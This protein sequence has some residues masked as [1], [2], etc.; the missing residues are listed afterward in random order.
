MSGISRGV[1]VMTGLGRIRIL[2][3][4]ECQDREEGCGCG[5]L[6]AWL[7]GLYLWCFPFVVR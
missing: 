1:C 5:V 3:R 2:K 6:S 4:V 7:C